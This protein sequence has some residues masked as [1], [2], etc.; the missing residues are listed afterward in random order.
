MV[1]ISYY[2]KILAIH[3]E[4]FRSYSVEG[5]VNGQAKSMKKLGIIVEKKATQS[6]I[7]G[8][9]QTFQ[10]FKGQICTI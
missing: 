8:R 7:I 9:V 10:S 6:N 2:Q 4:T 1:G 5:K 3:F